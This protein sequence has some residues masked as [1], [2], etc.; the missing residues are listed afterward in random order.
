[1]GRRRALLRRRARPGGLRRRPRGSGPAGDQRMTSHRF[2][3]TPRGPFALAQTRAFLEGWAPADARL[4]GGEPRLPCA[5]DAGERA[6][7]A[8]VTQDGETIRAALQT[9]GDPEQAAAQLWRMLSLD[10][11]ATAWPEAGRRD[12]VLGELQR[13]RH[14]FRPSLFGTPY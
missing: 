14:G 12:P 11:D 7:A 8:H 1:R 2:E 13:R 4:E 5:L 6:A 10:V 3:I 9:G